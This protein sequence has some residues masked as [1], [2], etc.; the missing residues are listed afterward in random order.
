VTSD[1]VKQKVRERYAKIAEGKIK[2]CC[3]ESTTPCESTYTT[4]TMAQQYAS[5]DLEGIPAGTD[6]GLGCGT[7]VAFLDLKEGDT[8]LDLGSGAGID[9]FIAAKKVG[10]T[11]R[12]IG[13]DMTV[14]MIG[15]AGENAR[16]IQA[17]NVEFRLGEI[18]NLPIESE[19]IDRV[20]SNCV[21]NLVP[22]KEKVFREIYRVLKPGGS[23]VVSD[24][25]SIGDIPAEI[26]RDMELWAGCVAGALEKSTYLDI[27]RRCGF[28]E[29]SILSEK[30]YDY[31]RT[32]RYAL[33]SVTVRGV[34]R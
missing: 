6:L 34:K 14:E 32:E 9:L 1:P 23:F 7:P 2:S 29:P 31:L 15:K 11:G 5:T 24:I 18:E 30:A 26:K 19:S 20:I 16:K 8:V 22:D 25:V 27:I 33:E 12:V 13:V 21:I 28:D 3:D 10:P 4:D 17:T